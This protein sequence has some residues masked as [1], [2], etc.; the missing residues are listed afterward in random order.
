[1]WTMSLL[2]DG[3]VV[4]RIPRLSNNK[5][6]DDD[7]GE[8]SLSREVAP[9]ED[10]TQVVE[11]LNTTIT[12]T[13]KAVEG[14]KLQ[15][16]SPSKNGCLMLCAE[17]NRV[18]QRVLA[19]ML[20]KFGQDYV[21]AENGEQ[22]VDIYKSSPERFPCILMDLA[23][24]VM[25]GLQATKLIRTFEASRPGHRR[26]LIVG[27][28]AH[29]SYRPEASLFLAQGFDLMFSKPYRMGELYDMFLGG[30]QTNVLMLYGSLTEE[31]KSVY[32]RQPEEEVKLGDDPRSNAIK[33]E[34]KRRA[35]SDCAPDFF[36]T[37][38]VKVVEAG[39]DE[40]SPRLEN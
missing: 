22:V 12:F 5:P 16:S 21:L 38:I 11:G 30:P 39:K 19:K 40:Q 6:R 14:E 20:S 13:F 32:P 36:T 33:D 2:R 4:R 7:S 37:I 28:T 3:S 25:D 26:A 35:D 8:N 24:P 9:I 29:S 23:M 31:E 27:L 18:N 17:D 10:I 15:P 1:M 34:L